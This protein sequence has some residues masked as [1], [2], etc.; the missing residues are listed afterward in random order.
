[1]TSFNR[2][3]FF[4]ILS[5]FIVACSS[6]QRISNA[7]KTKIKKVY[8]EPGIKSTEVMYYWGPSVMGFI[9]PSL[10]HLA[11]MS[12]GEA[13]AKLAIEKGILIEKIAESSL[14]KSIIEKKLFTVTQTKEEADAIIK[15]DVYLYGFSVPST[16]HPTVIPLIDMKVQMVDK[17][18]QVVWKDDDGLSMIDNSVTHVK[19]ELFF[20][21]PESI[22]KSW[23][24]AADEVCNDFTKDMFEN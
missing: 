13:I 15:T 9:T 10:S 5:L 22:R 12:E 3:R 4:F 17:N 16:M 1:M 8:C 14:K 20:K 7:N 18:N 11:T 6:T 24:E 2:Y 21:D 23:T 19:P